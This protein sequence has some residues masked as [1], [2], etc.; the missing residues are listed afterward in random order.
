MTEA[1]QAEKPKRKPAVRRKKKPEGFKTAILLAI[2]IVIAIVNLV[3]LVKMG[4][5]IP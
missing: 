4:V 3:L 1:V 2:S 5:T